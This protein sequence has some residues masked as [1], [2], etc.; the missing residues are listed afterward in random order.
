M[1]IQY[2]DNSGNIKKESFADRKAYDQWIETL[3]LAEWHN[4][5]S[6]DGDGTLNRFEIQE[7]ID[8]SS[9]KLGERVY[10]RYPG[11]SFPVCI[12]KGESRS[13]LSWGYGDDDSQW[14]S[15]EEIDR[16]LS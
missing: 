7:L 8:F 12:D 3:K 5:C 4:H 9:C 16:Q 14:L 11:F 15:N 10:G 1:K 2:K 13:L 6:G